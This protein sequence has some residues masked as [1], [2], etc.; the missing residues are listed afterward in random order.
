MVSRVLQCV[1]VCC[2]VL[3][4]ESVCVAACVDSCDMVP[5]YDVC[6]SVLQFVL[7]CVMTHMTPFC[8]MTCVAVC[9]SICCS[10]C[11]REC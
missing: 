5:W 4:Y 6:C 1:A 11:C 10:V 7:Q 9:C 3:Q 2:S 8:G